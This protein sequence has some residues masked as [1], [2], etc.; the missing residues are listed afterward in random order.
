VERL[1]LVA[2]LA[3]AIAAVATGVRLWA[4][5]RARQLA[6]TPVDRVWRALGTEPDGR[7]AVVA[8]STSACAEC[9][10]QAAQ[11]EPL[12]EEGVRLLSVDAAAQVDAARTFGVLT[13]PSTVVLGPDGRVMAVNHGLA[14]RTRIQRQLR[15]AAVE[16]GE[17]DTPAA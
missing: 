17:T 10:V 2:V 12:G 9:R 7:P 1:L 4:R 3:V 13:V 14:D 11:L 8:F 5:R 6:A 15:S 16:T